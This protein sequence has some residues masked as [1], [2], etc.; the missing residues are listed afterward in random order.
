MNEF[1]YKIEQLNCCKQLTICKQSPSSKGCCSWKKGIR[2]CPL[3]SLSEIWPVHSSGSRS[4]CTRYTQSVHPC[5]AQHPWIWH[6]TTENALFYP[7][8]LSL[9]YNNRRYL[10]EDVFKSGVTD[11]TF[12]TELEV[13]EGV[14]DEGKGLGTASL[15]SF[16]GV[17]LEKS[18]PLFI[19]AVV[20]VGCNKVKETPLEMHKMWFGKLRNAFWITDYNEWCIFL[21][22]SIFS[23]GQKSELNDY[24]KK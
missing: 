11:N 21:M 19:A 17:L 8:V 2:P 7:F 4:R 18:N 10:N 1:F 15:S 5:A 16:T 23:N 24:L 14:V 12:E 6:A 9:K 22:G 20:S 13:L 3:K